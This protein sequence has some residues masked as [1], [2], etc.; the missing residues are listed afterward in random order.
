MISTRCRCGHAA[1]AH[2]HYR[3]GR[4]CGAC[5]CARFVAAEAAVLPASV[6][7]A[8]GPAAVPP[9]GSTFGPLRRLLVSLPR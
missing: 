4:D 3:Q 9:L 1:D 6:G 5:R 2:E 7:A 8:G